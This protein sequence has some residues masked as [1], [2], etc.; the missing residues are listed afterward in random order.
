M[1]LKKVLT[2]KASIKLKQWKPYGTKVF[3]ITDNATIQSESQRTPSADAPAT[4]GTYTVKRVIVYGKLQK[5]FYG[6]GA[7]YTKI[8]GSNKDTVK[9]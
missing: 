3:T 1:K 6:N 7:D 4:G 8:A 5:Q 2:F 9:N